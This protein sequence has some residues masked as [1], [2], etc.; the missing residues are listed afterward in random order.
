[1]EV[2]HKFYNRISYYL[3][4]TF[5]ADRVGITMHTQD[6]RFSRKYQKTIS[7]VGMDGQMRKEFPSSQKLFGFMGKE[8]NFTVD[9]MNGRITLHIR[10]TKTIE[11]VLKKIEESRQE[12]QEEESEIMSIS[13]LEFPNFEESEEEKFT[14]VMQDFQREMEKAKKE[15]EEKIKTMETKVIDWKWK[16]SWTGGGEY[17]GKYEG[18][19]AEGKPHGL[20]KWTGDDD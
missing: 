4:V 5:A 10:R 14:R 3:T 8:D 18:E 15:W 1:M 17:H 12:R 7:R 19:L 11:I 9:P 2:S 6:L 16:A 20:G 13:H